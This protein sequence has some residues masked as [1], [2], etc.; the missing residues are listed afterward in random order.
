MS[1]LV[2]AAPANS[3]I[4]PDTIVFGSRSTYHVVYTE[5]GSGQAVHVF[6]SVPCN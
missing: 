1:L 4:T 3:T 6:G 2:H 5:E